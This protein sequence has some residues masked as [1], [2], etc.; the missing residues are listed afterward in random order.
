MPSGPAHRTAQRVIEE[1]LATRR[2]YT[3]AEAARALNIKDTWLKR[4]VTAA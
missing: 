4:W 3:R 2:C 1:E